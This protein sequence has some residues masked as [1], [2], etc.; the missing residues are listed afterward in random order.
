MTI[1]EK[2]IQDLIQESKRNVCLTNSTP[3]ITMLEE[4]FK[5]MSDMNL[6][7]MYVDIFGHPVNGTS[8]NTMEVL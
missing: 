7:A 8:N 6:F 3:E 5:R 4:A 1:R 2:A